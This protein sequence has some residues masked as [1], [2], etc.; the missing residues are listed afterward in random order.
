M[1]GIISYSE[2]RQG[3]VK[4]MDRLIV[5]IVEEGNQKFAASGGALEFTV[6]VQ[7]NEMEINIFYP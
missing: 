3:E 5:H 7:S 2:I 4:R 1:D 6:L